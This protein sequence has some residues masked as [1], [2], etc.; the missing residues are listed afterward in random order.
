MMIPLFSFKEHQQFSIWF[1][2][3]ED[4]GNQGK[5]WST[6]KEQQQQWQKFLGIGYDNH[7]LEIGYEISHHACPQN[8]MLFANS[9]E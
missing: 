3:N 6:N 8:W 4:L 1:C 5:Q 9:E 2:T 7:S